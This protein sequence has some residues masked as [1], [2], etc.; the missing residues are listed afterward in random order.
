MQKGA[1]YNNGVLAGILEKKDAANYSFAYT[2]EYFANR[3]MPAISL[4]FPK[5]TQVYNANE[6]FPFF[7]GLLAEGINKDIQC[8]LL[9]IDEEDD[10]TRLIK[11]AGEDTIGAITVKELNEPE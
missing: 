10:F 1:V 5:L 8:R 3:D 6:L 9:K 7:F 2:D 4:S 11:T